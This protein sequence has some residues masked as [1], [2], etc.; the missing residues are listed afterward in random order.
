M[1]ALLPS[2]AQKVDDDCCTNNCKKGNCSL[3]LN[4]A[5]A[6]RLIVDLD[7]ATLP[8]PARRKRCDYLFV[9]EKDRSAW[10]MPIELKEGGFKAGEV[11][12]QLQGGSDVADAWLPPGSL[13][14]LVP[15]LAH[16]KGAHKRDFRV[17]RRHTITL[18]GKKSRIE[19]LH[20][21]EKLTKKLS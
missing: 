8:I 16:G 13:F 9:G 3:S 18:R 20:C 21:G 2:V 14:R 1:S 10:V 7:C 6:R 19:T 4:D 11:V 17:L 5:P 15:I 12:E